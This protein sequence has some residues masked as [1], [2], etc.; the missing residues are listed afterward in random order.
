VARRLRRGFT[1]VEILIT[2]LVL[3]VAVVPLLE[4]YA[5][6]VEQLSYTDDMRTAIDLAREEVEKVKNLAL[7]EHQLKRLGNVISPPIRLNRSVWY[8]V[9]VVNETASPLEIQVLVYRDW[10]AGTP[11]A[12]LVTILQK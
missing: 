4:L 2:L 11:L 10:L 1:F 5:T 12:S 8:T 9:R 7:T 3:G 6:A